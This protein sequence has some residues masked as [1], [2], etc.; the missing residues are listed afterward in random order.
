MPTRS[1]PK[2]RRAKT[3]R[4]AQ[5]LVPDL[6]DD[7]LAKT[8]PPGQFKFTSKQGRA[9]RMQLLNAAK[10]LLQERPSEEVSLADVCQRADIPRASAYHFFSNIQAVFLGLR[11]LHAES[12]IEAL[13]AVR[14][15][16]FDH[17]RDYFGALIDQGARALRN[18]PAATQLVYGNLGSLS[19]ARRL[20]E[21]LDARL[22]EMAVQGLADRFA[23]PS[24]DQ[25]A[26]VFGVAFTLVDSVFRLSWRQHGTVTSWMQDE[27]RRAAISYLR[28]YLPEVLP[29]R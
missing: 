8:L 22:A 2:P 12:L 16:D 5:P 7:L 11:V 23:L 3:P 19:E 27:A 9:R 20:G 10:E 15:S 29:V 18:D 17:W 1:A 6:H 13:G 14:G 25:Q 28:N 4:T 21:V 24:W 26:Q